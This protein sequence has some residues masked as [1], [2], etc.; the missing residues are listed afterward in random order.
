[1][2]FKPG[3][4]LSRI[5]IIVIIISLAIS[6]LLLKY[7]IML[8]GSILFVVGH[9]FLFCNVTR[10]SR[11]PELIWASTL[12]LLS[13]KLNMLPWDMVLVLSLS[14]TVALVFLEVRKPY[15]HGV[16][17]KKLNPTLED[18]FRKNVSSR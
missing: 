3:L 13:I 10:M 16:L 15:Y 5:D 2:E 1:M 12:S 17:W 8:S 7:S 14:A 6:I 11:V 9:F 4:R 18:R